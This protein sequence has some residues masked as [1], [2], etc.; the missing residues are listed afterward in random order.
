M[1]PHVS[2]LIAQGV[3]LILR[4]EVQVGQRTLSGF[5]YTTHCQLQLSFDSN[6]LPERNVYF[7]ARAIGI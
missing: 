6:F 1:Q 3:G 2:Y 4:G 7:S 5:S